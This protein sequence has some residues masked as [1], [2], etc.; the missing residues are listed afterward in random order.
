[1]QRLGGQ[2]QHYAWGDR[3]A[4]PEMLGLPISDEPCAEYWMGAHPKAPSTID[5]ARLD[6]LIAAD[7]AGLLGEDV[8]AR[9]GAF[10]FLFKVLSAR[11]PLSIQT[12]PSATEAQDGFDREEA[13][14]IPIDAP[15]RVFRDRNHKPELIVAI[16][17]FEA[18]CGFR[19]VNEITEVLARVGGLEPITDVLTEAG[20]DTDAERIGRAVQFV[21][22]LSRDEA[23]P[24]IEAVMAESLVAKIAEHHPGDPG[25]L[26]VPFLHHIV[27]QPGDALFLAAGNLHAYLEGTAME[28]MA[29]S[30]NVVRGGLTPKHID[31]PE[32]LAV[33][34]FTPGPPP[35]QTV[36]GQRHTYFSPVP[37]F[38]LTRFEAGPAA[39][40]AVNG[41]E[42][43]FV[44]DGGAQ[45]RSEHGDDLFL[46]R[47]QAAFIQHDDGPYTL[48]SDGLVWRATLGNS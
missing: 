24:L 27:L 15:H 3:S 46:Q 2:V 18:L 28:L 33:T 20:A 13:A 45:L 44:S 16:T 10:P 34:D 48:R 39:V 42:I 23:A 30:D 4:I 21:L 47:G 1:M 17:A 25:L 38:S 22:S 9:F 31:V 40:L 26:V 11:A 14:G 29:N 7:P 19:T 37:E 43:V 35:R 32:L 8:S 41:P 36:S 6:E 5:G 12:H